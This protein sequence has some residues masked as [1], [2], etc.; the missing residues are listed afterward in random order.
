M[1]ENKIIKNYTAADIERYHRGLLSAKERHDLERAALDDPFLAEALEGYAV[2]GVNITADIAE[3]KRRLAER[4]EDKRT[5]VVPINKRFSFL[6]VAAAVVLMVGTAILVYQ[7]MF[8]KHDRNNGALSS[9]VCI[10]IFWWF[11]ASL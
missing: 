10:F 5:A 6:K 7:L 3:L 1:S 9:G 8:R 4:S 2:T 11:S